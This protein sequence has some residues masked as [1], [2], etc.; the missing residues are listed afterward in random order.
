MQKENF[1]ALLLAAG[2]GERYRASG[3]AGFKLLA[4]VAPGRS[5]VRQACENLMQAGWPVQV[6]VRERAEQ[7][8][9]A[10]AGLAVGFIELPADAQAGMSDSIRDAVVATQHADGWL[11]ALA[12]MPFLQA[13]TLH[14]VAAAVEEGAALAFPRHDGQRGHPVGFAA[15]LYLELVR[16]SGDHGAREVL[17]AHAGQAVVVDVDDPGVLRDVDVPADL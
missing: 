15:R 2:R 11:I 5:V 14:A 4:E 16:L 9:Q 13:H 8:R 17:R 12:D 6:V 7:V 1:V 3:G 10:L